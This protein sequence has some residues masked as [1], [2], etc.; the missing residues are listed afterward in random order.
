MKQNSITETG[1]IRPPLYRFMMH[2]LFGI[3]HNLDQYL[4]D[5]RAAAP[6]L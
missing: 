2:H 1:F 4:A 6:T 3:T 5:M